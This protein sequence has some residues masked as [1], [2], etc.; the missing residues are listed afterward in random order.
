MDP[1][2]V[3]G[4][5]PSATD[6]EVKKAYRDLVKKYHPDRYKDSALKERASEKLKE[7]NAAYD[8]V[9]R[10][11]QGKGADQSYGYGTYNT[12]TGSPKYSVVR[13]RIQT[14]DLSGADALLNAMTERDAEWYYLKGVIL[15][16]RGWYDGARQNFY[17][18]Y[19]MDPGN[20]EY[21]S[22]YNS[23][24]SFGG[25]FG[26][27]Y[28]GSGA[29]ECSMCDLCAGLMCMDMCCGNRCC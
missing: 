25:P 17:T 11:R 21:A 7:V 27:Y 14:G 26:R 19:Q 1:Y 16:R 18:A 29:N 28:A 6:E 9:T 3:L 4:V 12:S 20:R 5:S 13:S 10:I 22:A 8:E 23:V 15:L 2:Q 24:N